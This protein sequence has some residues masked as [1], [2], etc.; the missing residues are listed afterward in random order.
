MLFNIIVHDRVHNSTNV[1]DRFNFDSVE[2]AAKTSAWSH[3]GKDIEQPKE[4][5]P[6]SDLYTY[7]VY[8]DSNNNHLGTIFIQDLRSHS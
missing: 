5:A 7:E 3:F 4:F 2:D 1:D 6:F 8:D